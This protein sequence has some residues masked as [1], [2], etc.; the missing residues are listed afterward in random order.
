[1]KWKKKVLQTTDEQ[2]KNVRS[3]DSNHKR[4]YR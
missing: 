3:T 2:L 1:M 4:K